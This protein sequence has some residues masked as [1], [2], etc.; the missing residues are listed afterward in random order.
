MLGM[1]FTNCNEFGLSF[2]FEN[3]LL[4]HCS[5]Y[6]RK[7]K[8]TLFRNSQ[9]QETDFSECDLSGSLFDRCD[10]ARATFEHSL[11]EKADLRTSFNYSIDPET[12]RICK[13]KFSLQGVPGLLYKYDIEI[14]DI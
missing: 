9:L 1:L 6:Q 14:D 5:F 3:C 12:N 7:I 8:K 4:N 13:A 11:L 2:S 10:L